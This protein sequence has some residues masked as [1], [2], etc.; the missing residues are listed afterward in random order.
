MDEIEVLRRYAQRSACQEPMGIDVTDQ[1]LET[2]GRGRCERDWLSGTLRPLMTA[3]AASV[4][5]AVSLGVLA[6]QAVADLQ[7]PLASLFTPFVVTLQ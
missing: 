4:L 2:I 5:I 1:V 6:Q 3:A 7:D